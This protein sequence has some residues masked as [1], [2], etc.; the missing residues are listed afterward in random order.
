MSNSDIE[1]AIKEEL[2]RAQELLEAYQSIPT[3]AFGI[4]VIKNAIKL[5]E[6]AIQSQEAANMVVALKELRSLE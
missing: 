1:K 4:V 6:D 2:I 3:G 5:G